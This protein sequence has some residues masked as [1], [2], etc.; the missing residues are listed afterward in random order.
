NSLR[1]TFAAPRFRAP[2]QTR[3]RVRLDGLDDA[4]SAWTDETH[5]DYTNLWEGHYVFRVQARDVD[6]LLSQEDT[7]TFR[8]LP[9]WYRT[10]WAYAL[11]A[12]A[13]AAVTM[14]FARSNRRKLLRERAVSRRLR[15]VDKLKDDFLA[16]TSHELR[17]PLFGIIGLADSLID[18]A[19]GELPETARANLAMIAGSG[20]R[21]SQLVNDI[22]D[23][24]RITHGSLVLRTRPVDLQTLVDVVLT[25]QRPLAADK[26]LELINAVP[27]DLPAL[28]AD[29]ARLEQILHNLVGNAIKFTE[30]GKVEISAAR[31]GD[32]QIR[33]AVADTGIGISEDQLGKIFD[34]FEQADAGVQRTFGGTGL[35]LT[36]T[37]E[38]VELHGGR[39]WVESTL[40]E[41]ARFHFTLPVSSRTEGPPPASTPALARP[42]P[43]AALLSELQPIATPSVPAADDPNASGER[44][45]V[46]D[47]EPVNRQVLSNH[48]TLEGYEIELAASGPEALE[49]AEKQ[50]FDL[51]ILD[52]MMPKMS[53]Y[54]VCRAL[55]KRHSLDELPVVFL[56]AKNQVTDLVAGLDAGG[57]DYLTKPIGRDEL[58]ARVRT[59]LELVSVHRRL[60]RVAGDL[61]ARNAELAHFNYTVAHDLKNPLTTITNFL[62]LAR[63]DAASGRTD[64]LESDF[65]RLDAAAQKLRRM[66]DELFELSRVGF[67]AN[68]PEE[69][70]FG[71]LVRQALALLHEQI[72][73]RGV[74]VDVAADLPKVV[75]DRA[76][77]L[78]AIR[79]DM[80]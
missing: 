16:S 73:H 9:P 38:L 44:I 57:N 49:L 63:R 74:A 66:L 55:R 48:L 54:E 14:A 72:A 68:P 47:D 69:V 53:G 43:S 6:D 62:G 77:L 31:E 29:E 23:H 67:Q 19:A 51:V 61:E 2:E 37:R 17:T 1:F 12:L 76:R 28:D 27:P 70:D 64:R 45:L 13:L 3:Y 34:A 36:V 25:L 10:W 75:G 4:W 24:S 15:E 8:I 58:L 71:E 18:G 30:A 50:S 26:D 32:A 46:V 5:K 20:R 33:I 65:A 11:Y 80:A 35:G 40:G 41:G 21:L 39:I 22:L 59:H 56:T 52:V 79:Q 60:T 78:D 7:F 42:Q